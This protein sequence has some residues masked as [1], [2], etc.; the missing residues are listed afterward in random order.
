MDKEFKGFAELIADSSHGMVDLDI[1]FRELGFQ[2]VPFRSSVLCVPTRD[3]LVQLIDPPYLVVTLEEIEIAHLERVQ[4]GLKNFDLVFVFKDFNKPV[5]HINTIP[6]ELLEDVKSWLTDV[7]IPISEGQMNLNWVQIMK[8]VLA[9]PYQFFI[10]GGWAFLT[11][12]GESDE[13]EE[14]DDYSGSD[15]D[16]SGGGDD[17]DDDSESGEDWDALER[18]AAKADRNS[19]FD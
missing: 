15:D 18:K 5:V 9:D 11:G 14:S 1:P 13:E 16:G 7:D 2:G 12:Q 4:F 3:C 17:D 8:T 19:G 6:V 10:D